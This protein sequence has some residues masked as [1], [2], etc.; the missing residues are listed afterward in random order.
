M[1]GYMIGYSTNIGVKKKVNQDSLCIKKAQ[2]GQHLITMVVICDGMGG[3]S[4]GE[5]ASATVV[6]AFS[7]WFV[8]ELPYNNMYKEQEVIK[9]RWLE[10]AKELN[11]KIWNYGVKN[12]VQLGTTMSVL[13][14]LDE[15]KYL[16][17]HVGDSRIYG[18]QDSLVQLTEDHSYIAREI[19]H[20][21]M[22]KEQAAKDPRRNVLL[23]CIGASR[24]VEP[25]ILDGSLH[26]IQGFLLCSDGFHHQIP[27]EEI[28]KRIEEETLRDKHDID[29]MLDDLISIAIN[30]GETD[31]ISAILICGL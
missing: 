11:T 30:R 8:E 18:I 21:N 22:T 25:E 4:K 20:G 24:V 7:K 17:I 28:Y 31:N 16:I 27:E 26:D 15:E 19:K 3:L 12:G 9:K 1:R 2:I 23:Q 29:K 10:I 14:I 13:L 5:L 6:Q